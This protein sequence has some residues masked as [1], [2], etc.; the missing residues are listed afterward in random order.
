MR[1]CTDSA[2]ASS[3]PHACGNI[4]GVDFVIEI[5]KVTLVPGSIS[6]LMTGVA[7]GAVLLFIPKLHRV[8]RW[9]LAA[10]AAAYV[11]MATPLGAAVLQRGLGPVYPAVHSFRGCRRCADDRGPWKRCDHLRRRRARRRTSRLVRPRGRCSKGLACITCST[12]P[13]SLR[14]EASSCLAFSSSRRP[15]SWRRSWSTWACRVITSC[16]TR[17]Q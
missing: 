9:W 3:P 15:R 4:Q 1:W 10:L 13:P 14:Q 11:L 12:A 5:V 16:S 6:F 2:R 7:V 8:G 17:F